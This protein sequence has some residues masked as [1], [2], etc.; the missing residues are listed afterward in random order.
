MAYIIRKVSIRG[1]LGYK[2]INVELDPGVNFL[3]GRNGTG[4]TTFI[5]LLH[6]ILELDQSDLGNFKFD[7]V[8]IVYHDDENNIS[9]Q[10]KIERIGGRRN[11]YKYSFRNKGNEKLR[12]FGDDR[13]E[14][15]SPFDFN[16]GQRD[17]QLRIRQRN[18]NLAE[19]RETFQKNTKFSWLPLGRTTN[20]PRHYF[21]EEDGSEI[22]RDP[23]DNKISE[24]VNQMTSYFSILDSRTAAE[25]K[26]FQ[27]AYFL[28]LISFKAPDVTR[29]VRDA[30]K[31]NL[32]SQQAAMNTILSEMGLSNETITSEI[33]AFYNRAKAAAKNVDNPGTGLRVEDIFAVADFIRLEEIVEKFKQYE[34]KKKKIQHPKYELASLM[35]SML[36]NKEFVFSEA[37]QPVIINSVTRAP[38]NI[39]ELSSGEKQLLIIFTETMLQNRE[40]YI[41][42]ADEPEL[43]LHIDWQE[44]LVSNIK[45]LND[46]SQIIFAT[47]SP[48]VVSVFQNYV[49]DFEKL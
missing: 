26:L 31:L 41:F 7:E 49:I 27:E 2:D 40:K 39:T 1:F 43:S 33:A 37:N 20:V 23:I 36:L 35:S 19:L 21:D 25:T 8:N 38:I 34:E 10:L 5:K 47:H 15:V 3:I 12:T 4:K 9:P 45:K 6:A 14:V 24:L 46:R 48:D 17:L 22:Y 28:S 44:T 16:R 42:L 29:I 18:E 30:T 13:V 32:P 11:S